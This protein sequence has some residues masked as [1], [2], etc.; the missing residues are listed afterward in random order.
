MFDIKI[1]ELPG[2]QTKLEFEVSPENAK[3][4]LDEAVKDISE[5]KPLPGFRPGKAGYDDVKRVH[6]EMLIW[7]T[8]L[9][10]I[11][12]ASYVKTILE[13]NIDTVGSPE[14]SVDQLTPG[15]PMKFTLI[16]PVAPRVAKMADLDACH[17]TPKKAEITDKQVDEAIDE[18]R[19]MRRTEARV[20]RAATMED[21]VI[22]DLEMKK[23]HVVLEGGSGKDYRVYLAENHYIPGFNK[24]LEGIKPGEERTFSLPFPGEHFQKH[25]AGQ[26]VDF[27]AKATGVFELKMPEANEEFAKGLGLDSLIALRDKLKEN[28][29]LEAKQRV[30]EAAEIEMLEALVD[31]STFTDAPDILVNEEVRRMVHELEHSVEEQGMKWPDYLSSLKKSEDELRLDFVPQA[32][33]RIKTAVLVKEIAKAQNIEIPEEEADKEIDRIL[34]GIREGDKETRERVASPEYRDYVAVQMRNRKAL[35]WLKEKCIAKE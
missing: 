25:L 19:K 16:A 4:Y 22:I 17:I 9:E 13:K 20:E 8:A 6:G 12:R 5:Q 31:K 29:T 32:L 14:V 35:Q 7:Q 33:R 21:L 18:L 11:V 1:T 30:D 27:T 10:R 2:A 34:S 28:M 15:Q 23:D 3:P 24:E 26:K